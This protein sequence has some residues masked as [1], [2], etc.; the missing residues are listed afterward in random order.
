MRLTKIEIYSLLQKL[1]SLDYNEPMP[2]VNDLMLRVWSEHYR[3]IVRLIPDTIKGGN[4]L[5]I[6]IGYGVLAVLLREVYFCSVVATEH[7]SRGYLR[8]SEFMQ[9]MNKKGINI[10]EHELHQPLP[11]KDSTFDMVSCCDVVEHLPQSTLEHSLQEITR[12]LKPEGCLILST[13]NLAR[14]PNRLRF[15]LGY[16]I[17][18][19]LNPRKVGDTYDHIREFTSDEIRE[20][21]QSSFCVAKHE[22][23]LIPLFN[24]Q[25]N[26]LN[27]LLFNI[28]PEFGDELYILAKAIDKDRRCL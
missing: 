3:H 14:F 17:N 18:P 15:L 8:S 12:V 20:M 21:L 16:G 11:F 5:E 10:V 26:F 19:P 23:G 4:V 27:A 1:S 9:F 28:L 13:P 2:E 24:K 22:Y 7:P 25:F 6:G